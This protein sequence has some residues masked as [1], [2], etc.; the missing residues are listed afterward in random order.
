MK[1]S[2]DESKGKSK[3]RGDRMR[4]EIERMRLQRPLTFVAGIAHDRHK[5]QLVWSRILVKIWSN[6][7]LKSSFTFP[8]KAY[9]FKLYY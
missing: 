2:L 3:D 8:S 7:S 1:R 9:I 6:N 5:W 4:G